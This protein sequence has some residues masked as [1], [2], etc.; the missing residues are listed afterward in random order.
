MK[1][2]VVIVN[3]NSGQL[4]DQCLNHIL[5]Q[6]RSA[7][8]V[9]VVDNASEDGS[10]EIAA[11]RTGISLLKLDQNYGF[12]AANNRA[13]EQINDFDYAITLNPDA[14]AHPDFIA[15]LESAALKQTGF[16]SFASRMM[17]S[18]TVLDGV[19]DSYHISGLAWRSAHGKDW[20]PKV[21]YG[22]KTFSACAGA[23]MYR[24][25][26]VRAVGGFDES[27]FCYMEDVDLG[28]RLLLNGAPCLYVSNAVVEH[29]G[30]ATSSQYPGFAD[31]HGHRN[32]VWVLAKNTPWQLLPIVLPAHLLMSIAMAI[33]FLFRGSLGNYLKAKYSAIIGLSEA[34][35]HRAKVQNLKK[36]SAWKVLSHYH[37]GLWR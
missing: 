29:I 14:F 1:I 2:A 21:E 35:R 36:V 19:G 28:Y 32:L 30:S 22:R 18:E 9:L 7:D 34:L 10:A 24:L 27:F 17:Q 6:S 37:I 13:F 12:A 8:M 16:G 23:A 26:Q 15:N 4:L 33:V 20:N 31:F 5:S 3:Y 11:R 25:D